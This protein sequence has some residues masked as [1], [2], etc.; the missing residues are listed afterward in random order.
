MKPRLAIAAAVLVVAAGAAAG[1]RAL[2]GTDVEVA[3]VT[4]GTSV[5]AVYASGAVEAVDRVDVAARVGGPVV[6]LPF[7]EGDLVKKGDLVARIDAPVLG[8]DVTKARGDS[9][10]A[11]S[12]LAVGPA[13]EALRAQ[14]A[15]LAAQLAQAEGDL[16][17]VEALVRSGSTSSADLDRVRAQV[18][19]LRAQMA[20]S[21]AQERDLGIA[22]RADADRQ[23]V[24]LDT[25]R[26]KLGDTE[27]RAPLTGTVLSRKVDLG[28]VVAAT[29]TLLRIGDLSRLHL[30][31]NVDEA[32]V[33]RVQVGQEAAVRLYA[34][35]ADVFDGR[36]VKV[37]P[38]A[39]RDRKSF[40]VNVDL[41]APPP[42]LRPGMTVEV[43]IVLARHD[44]VLLAPI[45]A[46]HDGRVWVVAGGRAH[47]VPVT[48]RQRDLALAEIEG[49]PA[50]ALVVVGPPKKI[51]EGA[52]VRAVPR[53]VPA[54]ATPLTPTGQAGSAPDAAVR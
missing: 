8:L 27:V 35:G 45:E 18:E 39:D 11:S 14:R 46:V 30:E 4:R 33:A 53:A 2:R 44:A 48:V 52:R 16:A 28:A 29:Q 41:V 43:N 47:E 12:R 40:R 17:R 22:L 32:D 19:A 36:V 7:R 21:S 3:P 1:H 50:G 5:A 26:S 10:A 31:V 20:A 38:E 34:F 23:R 9:A 15:A 25:A 42:G 49:V 13:L 54:R 6:E 24:T 51:T 37:H